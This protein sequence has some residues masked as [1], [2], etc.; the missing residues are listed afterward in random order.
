VDSLFSNAG[1]TYS[2]PGIDS[3]KGG[4]DFSLTTRQIGHNVMT[5]GVDEHVHQDQRVHKI[6][7]MSHEDNSFET[8]EGGKV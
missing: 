6:G 8:S 4:A 1:S 7:V 3:L 2:E 5:L